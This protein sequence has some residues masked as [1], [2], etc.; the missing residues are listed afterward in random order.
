MTL[1]MK[2][3]PLAHALLGKEQ[4]FTIISQQ[5]CKWCVK[6]SDLLTE[7]G[8]YDHKIVYLEDAPWLKALFKELNV[9][10]VPQ[11]LYKDIVRIGGYEDLVK[12]L[13]HA[14]NNV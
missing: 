7:R 14:D 2:P 11:V 4:M 3:V 1:L 9:S 5:D 13:Y 12:W 8:Y 10:S 6:A